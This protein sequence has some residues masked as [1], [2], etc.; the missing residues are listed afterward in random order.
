MNSQHTPGPWEAN[1][2]KLAAHSSRIE[3]RGFN[4]AYK[5]A[6]DV[7]WKDAS[8]IAAAP[9]LLEALEEC[10]NLLEFMATEYVH[11]ETRE[12]IAYSDDGAL[13]MARDAIAKARGK[14]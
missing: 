11:K 6:S 8:L 1:K 2:S 9:E 7:G 10:A 4:G 5:I 3:I 14:A 13:S 12:P